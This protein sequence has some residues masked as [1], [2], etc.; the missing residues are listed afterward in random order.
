MVAI[1]QQLCGITC[2]FLV[3]LYFFETATP[4][5][6]K[7]CCVTGTSYG[8]MLREQLILALQERYCLETTIFMQDGA[9]SPHIDKPV[10]KI[11]TIPLVLTES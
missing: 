7:R 11:A 1:I 4:N 3:G 9:P 8:A 6:P 5:G 2:D 10:K